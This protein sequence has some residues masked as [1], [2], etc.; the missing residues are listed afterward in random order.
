MAPRTFKEH[1]MMN[2]INTV[3]KCEHEDSVNTAWLGILA[4]GADTD[5]T[6]TVK[7][8]QQITAP[9]SDVLP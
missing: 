2:T 4:F 7:Q 1:F 5:T 3:T 8:P 6:T 9:E